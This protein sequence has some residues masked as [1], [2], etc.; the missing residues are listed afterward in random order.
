MKISYSG[1]SCYRSCPQRFKL[2]YIDRK[3]PPEY[4][5]FVFGKLIHKVLEYAHSPRHLRAPSTD[6]VMMRYKELYAATSREFRT[7][8]PEYFAIGK[9][10]IS[11]HLARPAT[12][13]ATVAVEEFFTMP[14]ADSHKLVGVIDRVDKQPDGSLE[15]ID[16]KTSRTLPDQQQVNH[17][18]QLSIYW[19]A[20]R[21]LWP[22]APIHLTLYYLH[23]DHLFTSERTDRDFEEAAT[24]LL[25]IIEKIE[26]GA[27]P[28]RPGKQCDWCL[29]RSWC[30]VY[31]ASAPGREN[32]TAELVD[33]YAEAHA[34]RKKWEQTCLK[35]REEILEY[36]RT[37]E[38]DTLAS[39]DR[40]LT[41]KDIARH[42]FDY[43]RLKDL[44]QSLGKWDAVLKVDRQ[45]LDALLS[46]DEL[47]PMDRHLIRQTLVETDTHQQVVIKRRD[48]D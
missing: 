21:Y 11:R 43:A 42:D 7:Q 6:E 2:Q 19:A 46:G 25:E 26:R 48:S 45:K 22:H 32:R 8:N 31:V 36:C 1:A 12:P 23:F 38:V 34:Q 24:E 17:D 16:Y 47:T 9:E 18:L 14:L 30:P 4:A 39:P 20:A 3:S 37:H 5:P 13:A 27:F 28:P 40:I 44:L 35:L 15:I 29:Y 33:N 41:V 10:M